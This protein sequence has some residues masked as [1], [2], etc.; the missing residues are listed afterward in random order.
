MRRNAAQVGLLKMDTDKM[1]DIHIK[2]SKGVLLILL[3]ISLIL[4]SL[5][6]LCG[7]ARCDSNQYNYK[8][9]YLY[10]GIYCFYDDKYDNEYLVSYS[11]NDSGIRQGM[12]TICPRYK[13]DFNFA[14][15]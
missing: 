4:I 10:D 7:F 12:S 9:E 3:T 5:L 11:Y 2:I 1:I 6:F 15:R 8:I 13:H 14:K